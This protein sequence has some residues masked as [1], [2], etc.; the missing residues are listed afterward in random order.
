MTTLDDVVSA[1]TRLRWR[2]TV[3]YAWLLAGWLALG[4]RLQSAYEDPLADSFES[5]LADAWNTAGFAGRAAAATLVAGLLGAFLCHF[6]ER[7]SPR[8]LV[9]GR[10]S[11]PALTKLAGLVDT[12]DDDFDSVSEEDFKRA[13]SEFSQ[14]M[15]ENQLSMTAHSYIQLSVLPVLAVA[16]IRGANGWTIAGLCIAFVVP[17][18]HMVMIGIDLLRF[19]RDPFREM[20]ERDRLEQ[21]MHTGAE[22]GDE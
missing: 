21:A 11:G 6:V 1:T 15:R 7:R 13:M 17:T 18:V 8:S 20:R 22:P 4:D 12:E 16:V 19:T 14:T 5:L 10:F 2:L 9:D 3:G